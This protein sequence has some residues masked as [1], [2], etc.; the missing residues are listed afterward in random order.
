[1]EPTG[2]GRSDSG[3]KGTGGIPSRGNGMSKGP[4]AGRHVAQVSWGRGDPSHQAALNG[5]SGPRT[6][7]S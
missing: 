1:M 2:M 7:P 4:G 3:K 5:P 6:W